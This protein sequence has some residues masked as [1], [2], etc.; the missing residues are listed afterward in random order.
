MIEESVEVNGKWFTTLVSKAGNLHLIYKA[1]DKVRPLD[2][3]TIEMGQGQKTSRIV[4]W[5]FQNF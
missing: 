2:V 3:K 1:L 5:T 4:A